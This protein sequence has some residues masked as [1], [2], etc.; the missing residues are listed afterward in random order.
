[1]SQVCWSLVETTGTLKT[2][3]GYATLSSEFYVCPLGIR[4]WRMDP[5]SS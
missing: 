1:M 3:V 5:R 2:L 4:R